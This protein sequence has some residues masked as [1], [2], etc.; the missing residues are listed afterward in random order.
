VSCQ[1]LYLGIRC[2]SEA[3]SASQPRRRKPHVQE[4][5]CPA[6]GRESLDLRTP[7]SGSAVPARGSAAPASY[8]TPTPPA[9]ISGLIGLGRGG[10]GIAG[11]R[12]KH[13]ERVMLVCDDRN[14]HT[15]GPSTRS[16]RCTPKSC[17]DG[18]SG[19]QGQFR[20]ETEPSSAKLLT[21]RD[22]VRST[23][24]TVRLITQQLTVKSAQ[25]RLTAVQHQGAY[26][27]T[28]CWRGG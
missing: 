22:A 26:P 8:C 10:G 2:L 16:S 18:P 23:S 19:I 1:L 13:C 15:K 24:S 12:Y 25:S 20:I 5:H 6:N 17:C 21:V 27:S 3:V 28:G 9:P 14:T 7:C 4:V 11:G